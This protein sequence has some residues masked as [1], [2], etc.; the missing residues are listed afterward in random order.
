MGRFLDPRPQYEDDDGQPLINGKVF[1]FE[2]GSATDKDL[3]FDVN[4]SIVAPNPV[5]LSASGRM[6][7]TFFKGSARAKLTDANEIQFWDIDPIES[8]SSGQGGFPDW[9]AISRWEIPDYVIASD[10]NI[11]CSFV[12]NNI[13]NDPTTSPTSWEL[14]EF[15]GTWNPNI[16]YSTTNLVK[17]STGALFRSLTNS[18]LNNDPTTDTVN[19]SPAI[20]IPVDNVANAAVAQFSYQNFGGFN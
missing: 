10:D 2:S 18:N 19:W 20:D 5:I 4:F 3:F 15:L 1:I 9:N 7:N 11:Y 13:G 16:S 12:D 8:T 17:A 14:V 6:P